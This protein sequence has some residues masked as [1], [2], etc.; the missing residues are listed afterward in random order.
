VR[1]PSYIRNARAEERPW[2]PSNDRLAHDLNT[3]RD[4]PASVRPNGHDKI[5]EHARLK[6]AGRVAAHGLHNLVANYGRLADQQQ[7][8][9]RISDL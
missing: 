2:G 7:R 3:P 4:P 1:A 5:I 6:T 9:V 8:G